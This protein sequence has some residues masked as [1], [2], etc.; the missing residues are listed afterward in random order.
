MKDEIYYRDQTPPELALALI[1]YVPIE[2]GDTAVEPF[3]GE[4]AFYNAIR[5]K[6]LNVD[7]YEIED[8]K[9]YKDMKDK[10]DYIVT[11]PPFGKNGSFWRILLELIQKCDKCLALLG[12]DYCLSCLTPKRLKLLEGFGFHLNKMIRCNVRKWRGRYIFMI[13]TKEKNLGLDYI[14]GYW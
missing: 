7:W 6:T 2:F 13:F 4:K 3:A 5:K 9:D 10:Y 12:N 8:G 14:D 1:E 11:N